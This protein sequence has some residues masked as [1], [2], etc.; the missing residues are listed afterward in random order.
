MEDAPVW[1]ARA[2]RLRAVRD[3]AAVAASCLCLAAIAGG[4]NGA[5]PERLQ[6]RWVYVSYN[7]LVD[8]NVTKV[9]ALLERARAAGYNGVL[10]ADY[11]FQLLDQMPP[12]YFANVAKIRE[13]ASGLG[14]EIYPTVCPIGYSSGLLRH[15]PNLAE[16]LPVRDALFVA[17]NGQAELAPDPP[18]ALKGGDFEQAQNNRFGGWEAQDDPGVSSFADPLVRHGGGQSLRMENIGAADPEHGHGRVMQSVTVSPYRQ[19]HLSVWIRTEA[20]ETPRNVRA[21]VLAPSGRAL[22][23][24]EWN[25]RANQEWREYHA[26]FNS[27][28]NRQ[29]RVYLGVWEGKGAKIWWDDAALEEVGMVNLLRRGGCPLV[30]KGEEGTVYQEGKDFDPVRDPR[31][32]NSPYAG[33]YDVIHAA[34]AIRLTPGSRIREGQRLRATFHH[35]VTI[36]QGQVTCCLSEPKVYTLLK[37]QIERVTRLFEPKG[38]MMSHD[39]IRVANWC[40]TCR[41]RGLT[42]GQLLADNTRRCVEMIRAASPKARVYVWSDMFDPN[43]N[44]HDDYYLVNG[45]WAGS[46]EGLPRDVAVVNWYFAKRK[47]SLPWFAGRGHEQV[48]AGYYDGRPDQIRTWLD[49]ARGVPNVTGVMYTTWQNRYEDL[50]AFA[51]AAWGSERAGKP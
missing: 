44:A 14:L 30:V 22:S 39:E 26:V 38:F 17:H 11:K 7:L 15:D 41:Q 47:Q 32:G 21:A 23:Y 34:P 49:D 10:L 45:T 50:E 29:V 16:G 35:A 9:Q 33:E 1:N 4:L 20:F 48:L 40:D 12:N 25:V 5:Q 36:H 19:Y 31:M 46:W 42:P 24:V 6:H 13:T 18:V 37:D 2:L 43:H 51:K 8:E 3:A 28:E 27:L